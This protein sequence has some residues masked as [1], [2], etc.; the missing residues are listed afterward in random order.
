MQHYFSPGVRTVASM[1]RQGGTSAVCADSFMCTMMMIML[2][3]VVV[4]NGCTIGESGDDE[5]LLHDLSYCRACCHFPSLCNTWFGLKKRLCY[6][7]SRDRALE[8]L[9]QSINCGSYDGVAGSCVRDDQEKFVWKER[10]TCLL[11]M[12]SNT[13]RSIPQ[14]INQHGD[15]KVQKSARRATLNPR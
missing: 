15:S 12:T 6:W 8:C 7:L 11:H 2:L 1:G 10:P 4:A 9:L 5:S 14:P 13:T 3:L